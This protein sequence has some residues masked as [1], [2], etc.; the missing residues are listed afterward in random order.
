[1]LD[2]LLQTT[3]SISWRWTFVGPP[4]DALSRGRWDVLIP[5]KFY[6]RGDSASRLIRYPK[7]SDAYKKVGLASARA[8]IKMCQLAVEGSDVEVDPWEG[9]Q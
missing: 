2:F 7:V 9:L 6:D 5:R 3:V 1:M 8:R 4:I